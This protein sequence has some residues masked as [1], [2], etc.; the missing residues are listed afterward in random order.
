MF[1]SQIFNKM[2][3]SLAKFV[4]GLTGREVHFSQVEHGE[5][6]LSVDIKLNKFFEDVSKALDEPAMKM[7][8]VLEPG[9]TYVLQ[10][11][12]WSAV[13]PEIMEKFWVG[14][15]DNEITIVVID[16]NVNFVSIPDGYEIVKKTS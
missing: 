14:L 3:N 11:D 8:G 4:G 10:V 9:K 2:F 16:K 5:A 15:K 1:S 6:W 12:D 13:N 7:L